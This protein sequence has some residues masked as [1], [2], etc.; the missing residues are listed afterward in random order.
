MTE[1]RA[2]GIRTLLKRVP[3]FR[4]TYYLGIVVAQMAEDRWRSASSFDS[5]F[6]AEADPWN[7]SSRSEQERF[8]LTMSVLEK[9]G[10]GSFGRAVEVGCAEGIFTAQLAG[11]CGTLDAL[12]Y[13]RIAIGRARERVREKKVN[14]RM[15]DMR[16]DA[17]APGYDLVVAMGLLTSLYRP[18]DVKRVAGKLVDA[19]APSGFLLYSDVRQSRVF[20]DAWWGPIALR[21]GEQIR[22]YLSRRSDLETVSVADTDSHVFALFRKRGT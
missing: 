14:F 19:I 15:W 7:S 18:R 8:A 11:L 17:L 1:S 3:G 22:R 5:I 2:R 10:R 16:E 20:E 12:D 4:S 6:E 13:S 9:A 21:G